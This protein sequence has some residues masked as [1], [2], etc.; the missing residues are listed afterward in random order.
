MYNEWRKGEEGKFLIVL[1]T[2]YL[3]DKRMNKVGVNSTE[4]VLS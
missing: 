2:A 3:V 1:L 4:L